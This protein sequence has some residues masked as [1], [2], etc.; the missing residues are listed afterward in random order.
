MDF[1]L[2]ARPFVKTLAVFSVV[3]VNDEKN[4]STWIFFFASTTSSSE[5]FLFLTPP[6][7]LRGAFSTFG[8]FSMYAT[9]AFSSAARRD[10]VP[11]GGV[12]ETFSLFCRICKIDRR[13]IRTAKAE[14]MM[15]IR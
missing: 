1:V 6:T 3:V 7:I 10:G 5:D 14:R 2:C 11:G 13:V 4:T 9:G 8:F 15:G 12:I